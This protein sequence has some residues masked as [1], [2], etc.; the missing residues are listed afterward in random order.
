VISGVDVAEQ[1]LSIGAVSA[2]TGIPEST[3]RTWERRYGWPTPARTLGHQRLYEVSVV[4]HLHVVSRALALGHRPAQI[5]SMSRDALVELLGTSTGAE[6]ESWMRAVRDLDG[7]ALQRALL[8]SVASEGIVPSLDELVGPFLERVGE[9]WHAG[10]IHAFHEHFASEHV[11]EFLADLWRPLAAH[12][13][14]P[15]AVCATLPGETHVLGLHMAAVV[16][17]LRGWRVAFI[18]SD[19]PLENLASG[20]VQVGAEAL[21]LSVSASA[22][23]KEVRAALRDLRRLLPSGV[24]IVAGGAGAPDGTPGVEVVRKLA[25]I[26][27]A[28]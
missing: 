6:L 28:T 25:A 2:A 12:P 18:G 23:G 27:H 20:T 4:D 10:S 21:F 7:P 9:A 22:R 5:L 11:R 26:P 3:L 1:Q 13:T 17:A 16:L 14:G 19:T 8:G 15:I 24:R